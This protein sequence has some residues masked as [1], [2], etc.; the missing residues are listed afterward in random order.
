[1]FKEPT[2]KQ[3]KG[4]GEIEEKKVGA[5]GVISISYTR[6]TLELT[7]LFHREVVCLLFGYTF[8]VETKT[9]TLQEIPQSF[10]SGLT[11]GW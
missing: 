6:T 2:G 5:R 7:R 11:V 9:G 3:E 1:M 4:K 8:G 10:S